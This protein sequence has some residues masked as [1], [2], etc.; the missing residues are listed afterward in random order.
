MLACL[1][2][3]NIHCSCKV[4]WKL[5]FQCFEPW[6]S[7]APSKIAYAF[8]TLQR[9]ESW[10]YPWLLQRLLKTIASVFW[11]LNI[12]CSLKDCWTLLF[13]CFEPWISTAPSKIAEN[14]CFSILNLEYSLLPQRLLKTIVSVFWTLNIHCSL[15]RLLKTIASVFWTLNIHC[16][17][18]DCWK[19]LLPYFEPWISTAPSEIAEN[20]CFSV[21]NLEYPLLP[22]RLLKT[23]A[24]VFWTLNEYPL[25]PQRLLKT[26]ASVFW[27]LSIHCS[28]KDCWN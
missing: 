3:L 11:T 23:I 5:S 24:S 9:F 4:R 28:L 6:I 19:L 1:E 21:L 27:T 16:S 8:L 10:E 25:F 2:T 12:Y 22:Q 17:F 15:K 13:Q 7:T 26:I 14:Y 18:K 20:Y